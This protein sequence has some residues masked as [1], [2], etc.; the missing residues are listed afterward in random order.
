MS[1]CLSSAQHC[2]AHTKLAPHLYRGGSQP[3]LI[4][5]C[6]ES[7][8]PQSPFLIY[9][10]WNFLQRKLVSLPLQSLLSKD[11]ILCKGCCKIW[12]LEHPLALGRSVP[13]PHSQSPSL[14]V[15]AG[16]C[17]FPC[18]R[19]FSYR[20]KPACFQQSESPSVSYWLGLKRLLMCLPFFP[21]PWAHPALQ[22]HGRSVG[23]QCLL[24]CPQAWEV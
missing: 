12:S 18:L 3:P 20:R 1:C 4:C 23:E 24:G 22:P 16:P 14:R 13:F 10:L 7:F 8:S 17:L 9:L 6:A 19:D 2:A 11:T 21:F 5:L 15:R